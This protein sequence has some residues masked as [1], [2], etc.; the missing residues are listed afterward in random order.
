MTRSPDDLPPALP[1]LRRTLAIGY[2]AEPRLLLANF[3][4]TT[5]TALPDAL[6]ALWLAL[7]AR[8]VSDHDRRLV[9]G[10]AGYR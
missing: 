9:L 2:R 5:L 3:A 10:A 8:G 6:M 7:L 4:L 1:A